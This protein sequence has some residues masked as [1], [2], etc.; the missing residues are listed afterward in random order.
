MNTMKYRAF[1]EA[2][3]RGSLTR[4]AEMM[5]YTQSGVSHMI[6]ALE[7]EFGFPLLLRSKNGTA[8]T[9]DGRRVYDLCVRIVDTE[10]ELNH[11]VGMINGVVTGK[12]RIG[13]YFSVLTHWMPNVI[14]EFSKLYPQV[15]LQLFEGEMEEQFAMLNSGRID[16][17]VFSISPPEEYEFVPICQDELFIIIPRGHAL[18]EKKTLTRQDLL[19]YQNDFI[20][21]DESADEDFRLIFGEDARPSQN[22]YCVRS[23][24]T[25][26][27][28][29]EMGLGIAVT[30]GLL[31]SGKGNLNLE[32]RSLSPRRFRTLG[33][34]IPQFMVKMPT[35]KCF[36][37][38]FCRLYGTND[39]SESKG[40]EG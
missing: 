22:R 5:N 23:D 16:M 38:V 7:Q 20:L 17:G 19:Q 39:M 1:V 26:I 36:R 40:T 8:L 25:I 3:R 18:A 30:P 9:E 15:E 11:A 31:L 21:Q 14:R 29:V 12:L 24:S 35:V 34:V 13:A 2:V 28:L 33:L 37:N 6:A 10:D 32:V 27:A 4:A